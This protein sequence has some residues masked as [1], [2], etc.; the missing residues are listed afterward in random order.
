MT[1][2]KTI[3]FAELARGP[4]GKRALVLHGRNT[5]GK[6]VEVRIL[7]L[8]DYALAHIAEVAVDEVVR[9]RNHVQEQ[10]DRVKDSANR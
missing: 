1:V 8:Q 6:N 4:D 3:L 5:R 9:Q 2:I 7:D 10:I